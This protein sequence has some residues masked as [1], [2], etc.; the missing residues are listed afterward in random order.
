VAEAAANARSEARE[1]YQGYRA[2]YE[3]ASQYRDHVIPLRKK[4]SS[5]TLLRYN[6]MLASTFELLADAREQAGAVNAY[7]DALRD[8]WVAHATLE[9]T[10][11]ARL[12]AQPTNKEQQQ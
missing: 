12:G 4:I 5:E 10:L 2:A 7:I 3:L 1:A 9:A 6:G 8:F 11:G